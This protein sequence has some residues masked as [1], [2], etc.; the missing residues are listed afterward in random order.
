MP[1]HNDVSEHYTH[2][3]LIEAIAVAIDALGKTTDTITVDD[4]APVDE[5]HIGGR[6]A[7]E[8]F[9]DQ[10]SLSAER[11]VV[12]I[13]CGLGGAARFAAS[14]FG[15][16][17]TGIDLTDE[18]VE[19]GRVLSEWVGLDDRISLHQGS[20]LSMPFGD[21]GFD[22]A[23]MLH[24]GMNIADKAKLFSEVSR[25]LQPGSL[26]GIYDVMQTGEGALTFP[27]P[28]A[29]TAETSAV[30]EPE[31]YKALLE[32]A[33]FT[34]VNERNR[35]DFALAFFD[36]LRAATQAAGGPAPLGLHVLMGKSTPDKVQNMI[37]N[38]AAGRIAPVELIAR[39]S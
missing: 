2:G 21:A 17:V 11:H 30:A 10:L 39:K 24:V 37:A 31:N 9:L 36:Q 3:G 23:Y 26:F 28:W 4:L 18:F 16:K 12:D 1:E 38:I 7:S 8:E 5:F 34:I 19:T 35:R 33:G 27:V 20:A 22:A 25:V 14:R 15:C 29:A 6:R 32:A 13:G